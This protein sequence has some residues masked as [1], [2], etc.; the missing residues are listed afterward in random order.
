MSAASSEYTEG[1]E[2]F[3]DDMDYYDGAV[4]DITCIYMYICTI[5]PQWFGVK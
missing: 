5:I 4:S 2:I 3:S 1:S